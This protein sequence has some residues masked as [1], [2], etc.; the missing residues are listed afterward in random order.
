MSLLRLFVDDERFGLPRFWNVPSEAD[1]SDAVPR[2]FVIGGTVLALIPVVV[3]I[4]SLIAHA[5]STP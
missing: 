5:S 4:F 3:A 1:E 2:T